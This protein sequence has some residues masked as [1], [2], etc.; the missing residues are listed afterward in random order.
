[1]E[2]SSPN[3]SWASQRER[4]LRSESVYTAPGMEHTRPDIVASREGIATLALIR[5]QE[6]DG[7]LEGLV[8]AEEGIMR[9]KNNEHRSISATLI[10]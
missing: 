7:F 9:T 3:A 6:L 1:V 5:R 4:R 2:L 8:G 10:R